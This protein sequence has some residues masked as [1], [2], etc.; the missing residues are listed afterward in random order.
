VLQRLKQLRAMTS[1]T[2]KEFASQ[3]SNASSAA[4]CS[5]ILANATEA[6]QQLYEQP[7][8][9]SRQYLKK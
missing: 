2:A 6:L 4:V 8:S 3:A 5:E 9:L 1:K 7:V